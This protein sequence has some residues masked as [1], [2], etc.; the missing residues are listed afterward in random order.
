[1]SEPR[2]STLRGFV[3]A[4]VTLSGTAQVA[5]LWWLELG[6]PVVMTALCGFVYLLTGLGLFGVSRFA[7]ALAT[8][9]CGLRATSGFNALPLA[10]WEQLRT[11]TDLLVAVACAWLLWH[12][13]AARSR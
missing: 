4:A 9:L 13:H 5:M 6:R 3:A 11:L 8:V 7:L 10:Q 12:A 1:M 2:S